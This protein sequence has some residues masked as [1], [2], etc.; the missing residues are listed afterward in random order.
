MSPRKFTE[1][2][3]IFGRWLRGLDFRHRFTLLFHLGYAVAYGDQHVAPNHQIGLGADGAVA[4]HNNCFV[5]DCP[6]CLVSP[7]NGGVDT[8]AVFIVDKR[9]IW[10]PKNIAQHHYVCLLHI[11]P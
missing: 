9:D 3:L 10:I 2:G 6:N 5:S 7:G 8:A 1:F 11:D 4:R